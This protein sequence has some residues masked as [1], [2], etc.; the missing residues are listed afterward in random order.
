MKKN[1]KPD[2]DRLLVKYLLEE[3]T[4]AERAEVDGWCAAGAENRQYFEDFRRIWAESLRLTPEVSV[5]EVEAWERFKQ[6]ERFPGRAGSAR[7]R[8]GDEGASRGRVRP[9]EDGASN[10]RVR[11]LRLMVAAVVVVLAGI[12]V[13]WAVTGGLLG[14]GDAL[15]LEA[16]AVVRTDTLP[17]GTQVTLNKHSALVCPRVFGGDARTVR[18]DGEGFFQVKHRSQPFVVR[19]NGVTIRDLGTSFNVKAGKDETEIV[20]ESGEV[21]VSSGSFDVKAGAGEKVIVAAQPAASRKIAAADQLYQYYRT[22]AFVCRQTPL[23]RLAAVLSEAYNVHIVIP[24]K[25]VQEMTLTATYFR[26]QDLD[27]IL[28][29]IDKSLTIIHTRAGQEII[30]QPKN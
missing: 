30:F 7:V 21:E 12:G 26:D 29:V 22:S 17:D 19:L 4:D 8:Q 16:G 27:S 13:W 24:S 14:G 28:S 25:E 23:W 20:V 15:R 2:M 18:L 9:G 6:S 3:A 11:S 1:P 5:D 10:G